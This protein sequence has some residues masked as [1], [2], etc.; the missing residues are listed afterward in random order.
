MRA[1]A[2][3]TLRRLDSSKALYQH[4]VT[5]QARRARLCVAFLHWVCSLTRV[6]EP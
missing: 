3:N 5:I 4:A 1:F 2:G 6:A